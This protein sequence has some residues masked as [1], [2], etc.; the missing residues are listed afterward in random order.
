MSG[1]RVS[2]VTPPPH[3]RGWRIAPA[4]LP[5]TKKRG[6]TFT[7]TDSTQNLGAVGAGASATRHFLSLDPVKST[8]D[9]LLGTRSVPA[10]TPG[11]G[12]PGTITVTIP[13]TTASNAYYVLTC[14]DA[15]SVVAETNEANNCTASAAT[16]T[17]TP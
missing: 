14:A 1:D 6:T 5:A 7:V 15:T 16:M 3:A 8:N 13:G 11:P 10:V 9:I 17:I 4:A 2:I 12:H